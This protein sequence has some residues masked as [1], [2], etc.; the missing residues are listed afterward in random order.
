MSWRGIAGGI[1]AARAGHDV[2]MAP[3]SHTYFDHTEGD[4]RYEPL[5]IGGYVP[6]DT[7]YSFE[8]IPDSLTAEQAVHILGSQAQLWSEYL[9]TTEQIEYMAYPRVLA[10]SE[11]VWTPKSLRS[12]DSFRR[13]LLPQILALDALGV[14]N[15][16]P[17]VK[18][19]EKD[20]VLTG[21]SLVVELHTA[22]PESEIR[23]TLDGSQPTRQSPLYTRPLQLPMSA[24]SVQVSARAFLGERRESP[25]RSAVFRRRAQ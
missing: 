16:F 11:V 6:M 5:S 10:L 8:P 21:D 25:T 4:R 15:R 24:D 14:R 17:D 9:P 18:G 23:Y 19:L 7:V 1:A 22:V 2:I 20:R 13:R 12:W 3:G